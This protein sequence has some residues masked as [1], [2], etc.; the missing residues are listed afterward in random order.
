M[1]RFLSIALLLTL[2]TFAQEDGQDEPVLK[3]TGIDVRGRGEDREMV[4]HGRTDLPSGVDVSLALS[5][6]RHQLEYASQCRIVTVGFGDPIPGSAIVEKE[7]GEFTALA[8]LPTEAASL[9]RLDL[10]FNPFGQRTKA[11]EK[12]AARFRPHQ[13]DLT[14]V[15][16]DPAEFVDRLKSQREDLIKRID[17]L[18]KLFREIKR[19]FEQDT[20]KTNHKGYLD[21]VQ[22]LGERVSDELPLSAY[23]A[24]LGAVLD[25]LVKLENLMPE[26]N[27]F[28]VDP[29]SEMGG[30]F[31]T[32]APDIP[33]QAGDT[34]L[35]QAIEA[36]LGRM[37][38]ALPRERILAPFYV[39]R[40]HWEQAILEMN[41]AAV[42][43]RDVA[44][45]LERFTKAVQ[46]SRTN[47]K[48][49]LADLPRKESDYSESDKL[50]Q[51]WLDAAESVFGKMQSFLEDRKASLP[52]TL[53]PREAEEQR[54]KEEQTRTE[55]ET[56]EQTLRFVPKS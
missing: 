16:L 6:Q 18:E 8:G 2:P 11:A 52:R 21:Q 39:S 54:T 53:E 45:A 3:F 40:L 15:L 36:Y 19:E 5:P 35:L 31:A 32:E 10:A 12:S 51:E 14:V 1:V 13:V 34:W 20:W 28:E 25:S 46:A 37:R 43:D 49:V 24:T 4:V 27:K 30:K 7:G 56:V 33:W 22:Q 44:A 47:A 29:N 26:E 9:Y 17:E 50:T 48:K 42:D 55:V 41:R 38:R 23:P